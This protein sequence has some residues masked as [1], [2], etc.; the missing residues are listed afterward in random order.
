MG[1][2]KRGWRRRL[3]NG[4]ESGRCDF[5]YERRLG[6]EGRRALLDGSDPR[7]ARQGHASSI[8]WR[9]RWGVGGVGSAGAWLGQPSGGGGAWEHPPARVSKPRARWLGPAGARGAT[10][11]KEGRMGLREGVERRWAEGELGWLLKEGRRWA[12]AAAA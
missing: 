4:E 10:G 3:G 5:L 2:E 6:F 8:S 1:R 12:A 9:S 11:P 7:E